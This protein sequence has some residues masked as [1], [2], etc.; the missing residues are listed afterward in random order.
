MKINAIWPDITNSTGNIISGQG[1]SLKQTAP[2]VD[3]D[4]KFS[5]T[6]TI[7]NSTSVNATSPYK[8]GYTDRS[9]P[10]AYGLGNEGADIWAPGRSWTNYGA[11]GWNLLGNPFTSAMN[12]GTFVSTNT[13]SFDPAYKA[14]YIYD[15]PNNQYKYAAASVPGYTADGLFGENIQVG[16]GFYV[17]ALYNGIGFNF[18]PVMQVHNTTVSMTKSG[19]ADSLSKTAKSEA[20]WPGI[21]L[22]VKY[23]DREGLTTIVYNE[24]M[25]AGLDPGYDVGQFS[26]GPAVE[27]YT[28][29]VSENNGVNFTRQALPLDD[30]EKNIVPVGID[31]EMG[32]E[33]T[34]S[35]Y[36]VPLENYKFFLEDRKMNTF[37]DMI[38]NSYTVTIPEKTYGTGRFFIHTST[39]KDIMKKPEI[40]NH[41][42]VKVWISF[43]NVIIEGAVSSKAIAEVYNLHGIKIFETKLLEGLYNSFPVPASS[44]GIYV[45]RVIDGAKVVMKKVIVL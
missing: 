23:G 37:T 39:N 45:V 18:T 9:T 44:K 25:S 17:L 2:S 40:S 16:Q 20:P 14:L 13:D 22:K 34:F 42:N 15:K 4:S 38:T 28:S 3:N 21:Q 12:A 10:A 11:G 30:C 26:S 27:I 35:A 19:K 36:T 41:L 43:G 31:L 24:K 5:F 8:N 33:V 7:V 6:G 32:G 1:Y 29:L